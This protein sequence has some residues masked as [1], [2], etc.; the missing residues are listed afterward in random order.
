MSSPSERASKAAASVVYADQEVAV[1]LALEA[2]HNPALGLDRSVYLRDV[3]EAL[4]AMRTES[5]TGTI[6]KHDAA[7]HVETTFGGGA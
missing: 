5:T 1:S 7:N 6:T 3:V 4:R 2:A